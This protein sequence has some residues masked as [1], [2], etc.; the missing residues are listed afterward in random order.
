MKFKPISS[1]GLKT[2]SIK[3]RKS[4]VSV[5]DFAS[6]A[7]KGGSFAGFL[8]SLPGILAAK[9]LLEVAAAVT[10]AHGNK[11]TVALGMGAHV[12]KVGLSPLIIDLMERG[13]INSVAMN[14]ACVVH[15]FE[16]AFAGCTSEDVDAE[17]GS[18]AF[19]MAEETGRLINQAIKK[20]AKKGLGAAVG[21]MI[22]KSSFPHK[23]KS[24]LAAGSRLGVP[25]TVHVALGTDIIH[26]HPQMDGGA[27]GEASTIDF[28]I[29]SS[30]VSTLAGG[31]YIN[32]GSAV[33]MPEVFL[34]ALTLVRNLGH[35]VKGFSTV[36]MDFFQHY[37]PLTNVVRRPTMGGGGKGYRLTGHH[38]IMVPLLYGAIIEGLG[39][40]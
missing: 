26:L 10:S 38:E 9:D 24:I 18:G 15:D 11:K 13:V 29:F 16:T 39:K 28:R 36:N 27:T 12:I 3:D 8:G 25:V 19:G 31:M 5:G 1:K 40:R 33:I 20:G 7:K 30:V 32:I 6:C 4:K 37:R 22:A 2:Y 35:D 23:D 34:K 17:L 21:S 14:G